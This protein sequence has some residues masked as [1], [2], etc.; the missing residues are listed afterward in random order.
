MKVKIVLGSRGSKLAL[1]QAESVK[2]RLIESVPNLI[3][4]IKT[5]KTEGDQDST[6]P[7]SS[8]GG[9]GAFVTALETALLN[10]EI[11]AAVHS[12]KDLP[13][14][15][16]KGLA[17]CAVPEREDI[18]DVIITKTGIR[19]ANLPQGSTIGTGSERRAVQLK[20]IRPDL[21]FKNIRGNIDTRLDKLSCDEFDAVVI[22]AAAMKRLG[23]TSIIT[24]Y[25][26]QE[27][28]LP[29]PCQGAIGIECRDNDT[30]VLSMMSGIDDISVRVCV[31]TERAFIKTLGMGCHMP[32]GAYA[33][34]GG[35][36]IIFNAFV[37]Y[38]G[39]RIIEKTLQAPKGII[40][41]AVQELALQMRVKI[42]KDISQKQF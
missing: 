28:Y 16:T 35:G 30:D 25:I 36:G 40:I 34:I 42:N 6:S 24:D 26:N 31:E 11:D 38:G 13:S 32:V 10:E 14:S 9:R 8:F 41:K 18:R 15:L 33:K 19:F 39:G 23:M 1:I 3:V 12:L 5:I 27:N 7:L 17:L 20:R 29:A 37:A 2:T 4:D 21:K 22:S